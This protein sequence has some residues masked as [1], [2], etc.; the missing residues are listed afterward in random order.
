MPTDRVPSPTEEDLARLERL[1]RSNPRVV[2]WPSPARSDPAFET[3]EIELD[4]DSSEDA[5]A[6]AREAGD[7]L[8]AG[9]RLR[10]RASL[11]ALAGVEHPLLRDAAAALAASLALDFDAGLAFPL[12]SGA[13]AVMGIVNVTPDSFSDGGRLLEPAAA[14]ECGAAMAAAGAAL[15]DVGGESTRPGAAPVSEAE[16]L[17]RVIPVVLGLAER[18]LPAAI[19]IDT[20]KAAVAREALAAGATVVNDVTALRGDPEMAPTVARAGA[21]VVLMHMKGTP[22]DMQRSPAYDGGVTEAVSRY[23]RESLLAAA[24]AGI[25]EA[26]ACVDPGFGFGKTREHNFELLRR[27]REFTSLG[28]PVLAGLS[29]KSMLAKPGGDSPADR[30]PATIAATAAAA[31]AGAAIVR[32]HDVPSAVEAVRVAAA[33]RA[34]A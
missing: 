10:V 6:A 21:V 13:P 19:S 18:G 17:R 8:A 2:S 34:G 22:R 24:R 30:Q 27:L 26:R 9:T 33:I 32:V 15:I 25:P 11:P 28:R 4:A 23:L 7:A 5:A 20:R 31:L 16:E 14:V 3:H 1:V 29:R 12:R